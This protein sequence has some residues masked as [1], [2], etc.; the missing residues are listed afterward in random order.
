MTTIVSFVIV[1]G[2]LI[3]IHELGHFLVAKFT[4]VGVEKFSLGFG[5]KIVGIKRGE[6]EYMISLLPL[7][8]YVKM[9]GES[10][11]EEVPEEEKDRSFTHKPLSARTA[12]V[13]SGP[14]MNIILAV[15][16]FPVIF[17][18]GITVPA[19]LDAPP[20]VGFVAPDSAG[21]E[22]GLKRGDLIKAVDGK[23][24]GTWEELESVIAL[25]PG[26]ELSVE[27]RR[28]GR[29]LRT[30]LKPRSSDAT[31]TGTAGLYPP[32]KPVIGAVTKGYP[33]AEA[34]LKP[35]DV[36]KAVDGKDITY[37]AE[38]EELI[39]RSPGEKTFV[40]ERDGKTFTV[41]L[42]PRYNPDARVYLV[43]ISPHMDLKV[44][45]YGFFE[46]IKMGVAKAVDLTVLLFVVVK[47]LVVGE[48][49]IKTLGG[50]IMIAQV[51]GQ[52]AESGLTDLLSLMAFLSL[53]LGIINLFPIP[54]LDGGHLLFF[55]IEFVRGKPLSEKVMG[56]AQQVGIALLIALMVLV[57]WNDIFRILG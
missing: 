37:W 31:G 38:L 11:E 5:P 35:G 34:G 50:P 33:A 54:V 10:P 47:K 22:A 53:Q 41:K 27:V 28:D 46:S 21:A 51:A 56:V 12:I 36:I 29:I 19:F 52:A 8:G 14:I 4:G 20:E 17:M 26:K 44:K 39:H 42:T 49:S 57:T 40:I 2:I 7:G 30:T 9:T 13:A 45:S 6:T 1:L 43:G 32:M 55:A 15:L 3:F 24:I 48:V 25:N 16:L 18:I 23:S